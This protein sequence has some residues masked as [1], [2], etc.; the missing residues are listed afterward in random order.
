MLN[1]LLLIDI[2]LNDYERRAWGPEG[3]MAPAGY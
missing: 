2:T 3:A 1:F